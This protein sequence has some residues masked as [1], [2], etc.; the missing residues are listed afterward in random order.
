MV[1]FLIFLLGGD[2][3]KFEDNFRRKEENVGVILDLRYFNFGTKTYN[4]IVR[5]VVLNK[6]I[7]IGLILIFLWI[8]YIWGLW[9]SKGFF[10]KT[11]CNILEKKGKVYKILK[12]EGI[13][14]KM[15]MTVIRW[16]N[17]IARS[18]CWKAATTRKDWAPYQE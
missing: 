18:I 10:Q 12:S 5:Y 7:Q 15:C 17:S 16:K 9:R 14:S 13:E 1:F 3:C 6:I 4:F 11:C 2:W 8:N